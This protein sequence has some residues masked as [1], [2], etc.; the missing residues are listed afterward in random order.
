MT[1]VLYW[2]AGLVVVAAVVVAALLP[3][4]CSEGSNE[5][6]SG[7]CVKTSVDDEGTIN[8]TIEAPPA[9]APLHVAIVASGLVIGAAIVVIARKRNVTDVGDREESGGEGGVEPRTS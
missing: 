2:I 7:M 1:K 9:I 4:E 5:G 8:L 3:K 6:V